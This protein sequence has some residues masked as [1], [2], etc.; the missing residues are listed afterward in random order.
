MG[1]YDKLRKENKRIVAEVKK[2]ASYFQDVADE[3]GRVSKIYEVPNIILSDIERDFN[4]ATKLNGVD[5][6]FLFF[7]TAL[8]CVRQYFWTPFMLE[9]ERPDDTKAAGK[10]PQKSDR[11]HQ[12]YNP[13]LEEIINN[14]VPFDANVKAEHIDSV[15]KG[16][17]KRFGHRLTLGHDPILGW[18]VGTANIATSTLTTWDMRS[19]HVKTGVVKKKNNTQALQDIISNHADTKKVFEYTTDKLL[20]KGIEGKTIIATSLIK[21]WEHLKSDVNSKHS[22]PFPIVST[23]SPDIANKLAEY[24]IDMCNLLTVGKQATYAATINFIIAL[25]H[26]MVGMQY[27]DLS[28]SMY[29]V[30]TRKILTYSNVIASASNIIAVLLTDQVKYLDVGGLLVTMYRLITDYEFIKQVKIEFMQNHWYD[31]VL[32]DDYDFMKTIN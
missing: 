4:N 26:R 3:Y 24:G 6:T 28:A 22:L 25:I 9:G 32:G 21:E 17:G 13:S 11:H 15:F 8:Q 18:L 19:Y 27:S 7:A 31:I 10:K 5:A 30:K 20:H 29:E 23:I 12:W 1:K 2:E 16:A 14:P